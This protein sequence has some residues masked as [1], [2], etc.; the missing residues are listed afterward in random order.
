M[1]RVEADEATYNLHIII[2]F[3]LEQALINEGLAVKDLPAAWNQKYRDY[4]GI[5]PPSDAN[6]VLQDVHWSAALIGYFPTYALG[7]L[8]A[9]QFFAQAAKDVGPLDEQF[10]RGEFTGLL[11]WLR[12]KIHQQGQR[13]T[14][15]E[16]VEKVTGKPLSHDALINYLREKYT[17]YY[18][19]D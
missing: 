9:A 10:E 12:E 16:L 19:I 15:R 3:E 14:A 13:Y 1:I 8:Y 7:N 6:G 2:R 5:E 4:L 18:G 17:G 11:G